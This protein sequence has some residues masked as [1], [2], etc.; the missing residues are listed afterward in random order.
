MAE[1]TTGTNLANT[2]GGVLARISTVFQN[3]VYYL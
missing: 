2:N 3:D 1:A